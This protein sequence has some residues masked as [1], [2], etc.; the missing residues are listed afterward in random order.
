[1]CIFIRINLNFCTNT[2]L[3]SSRYSVSLRAKHSVG[4]RGKALTNT[5]QKTVHSFVNSHNYIH[6]RWS[7]FTFPGQNEPRPGH[8][9]LWVNS[10][11]IP[12]IPGR[13]AS[14]RHCMAER[15]A[16]VTTTSL[17][18]LTIDNRIYNSRLHSPHQL[19]RRKC[20]QC[21][22]PKKWRTLRKTGCYW[23]EEY[24]T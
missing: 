11:T 19:R 24:A 5:M 22:H 23:A 8:G 15:T 18:E 20:P 12:A 6:G 14:L 2:R 9:T 16:T 13:L 17:A 21:Y 7:I 4:Y 3:L 1:M 10:G